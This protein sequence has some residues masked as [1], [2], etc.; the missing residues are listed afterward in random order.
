MTTLKSVKKV[1]KIQMVCLRIL[2][3]LKVTKKGNKTHTKSIKEK[4]NTKKMKEKANKSN[5]EKAN[6]KK[7]TNTR[8]MKEKR[9]KNNNRNSKMVICPFY[10]SLH[11]RLRRILHQLKHSANSEHK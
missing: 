6:K 7:K 4:A 1:R 8:R 5:K 10:F 11:L 9:K 2:M 3:G